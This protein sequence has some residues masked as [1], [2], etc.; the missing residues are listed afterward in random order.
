MLFKHFGLGESVE[1]PKKVE[2]G[3]ETEENEN[4]DLMFAEPREVTPKGKEELK[5]KLE[6]EL[7]EILKELGLN[8]PS[9]AQILNNLRSSKKAIS[10]EDAVRAAN[11]ME[12]LAELKDISD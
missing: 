9:L 10:Q 5:N 3:I 12:K 1:I 6:A 2:T 4:T 8:N 11:F 7:E